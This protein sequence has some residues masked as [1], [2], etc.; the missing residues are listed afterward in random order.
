M[1]IYE[2]VVSL[3]NLKNAVS[4]FYS[5]VDESLNHDI[6]SNFINIFKTVY[7]FDISNTF[8]SFE[9]DQ[10]VFEEESIELIYDFKYGVASICIM[11]LCHY[12][13]VF[14]ASFSLS[15]DFPNRLYADITPL[16]EIDKDMQLIQAKFNRVFEFVTSIYNPKIRSTDW[17]A[18][19]VNTV[20]ANNQNKRHSFEYQ[21]NKL[22]NIYEDNIINLLDT[23]LN[24]FFVS[25]P[26]DFDTLLFRY[27]QLNGY[28]PKAFYEVFSEKK[29]Y[30]EIVQ[31][32]NNMVECLNMFLDDYLE[33]KEM[34]ASRLSV[35]EMRFI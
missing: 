10:I 9:G 29:D 21:S 31:S 1:T 12:D 13:E 2:R 15:D 22:Y 28:Q 30:L 11:N 7:N 5:C 8:D 23:N 33:N 32:P 17:S 19:L 25:P 20:I 6:I 34:L 35:L 18:C 27:L 3:Y 16:I 24:S 26:D 4:E 14:N